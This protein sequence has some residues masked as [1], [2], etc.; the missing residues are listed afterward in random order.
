MSTLCH[1]LAHIK[2]GNHGPDFQ[3]LW[4]RLRTEVRELQNKGYYGDGYWSSGKRLADSATVSGEGVD[5]G[6]FPEYMCGGAQSRSRPFQKSTRRRGP[7]R[8]KPIIPSNHT[9]RQT[10]KKR[11]P[12]SRVTSKYAFEGQGIT[13]ND[14][15]TSG[16]GKGKRAA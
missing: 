3:A 10:E 14:S 5:H 8:P 6:Q 15:D 7:R 2:H 16:T 11:K 4:R 1:E 9:G 12:G 13:L